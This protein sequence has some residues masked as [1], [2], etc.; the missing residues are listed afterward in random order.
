MTEN[1]TVVTI[2]GE[3]MADGI[4]TLAKSGQKLV[5]VDSKIVRVIIQSIFETKKGILTIE[6]TIFQKP[7]I[8]DFVFIDKN[9]YAQD[10]QYRLSLFKTIVVENGRIIG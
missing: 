7:E 9:K 5:I 6:H 10:G 2:E 3:P 1:K 4:V 8:G